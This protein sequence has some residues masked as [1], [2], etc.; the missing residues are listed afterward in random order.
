MWE[1]HNKLVDVVNM[2]SIAYF[3]DV[4][5][6]L[7]EELES[8]YRRSGEDD[9]NRSAFQDALYAIICERDGETG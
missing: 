5:V 2:V 1:E 6:M 7:R 3:T 8:V 9:P 4:F